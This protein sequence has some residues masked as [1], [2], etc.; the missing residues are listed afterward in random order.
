M[1]RDMNLITIPFDNAKIRYLNETQTGQD[2]T[3]WDL[4]G[5]A[6]SSRLF[7]IQ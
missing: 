2:E 3:F 7:L 6:H 1:Q 4:L 5:H